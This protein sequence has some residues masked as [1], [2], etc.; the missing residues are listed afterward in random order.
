MLS[1]YL[2][3]LF[4]P[5]FGLAAPVLAR[6]LPTPVAT[7]LVSGGGLLAAA[8]SSASLALLARA[9]ARRSVRVHDC[10]DQQHSRDKQ[11]EA[12]NERRTAAYP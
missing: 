6:G 8:G 4:T 9:P 12:E 11:Q 7:W 10:E 5:V 3:L 1:V 2:P